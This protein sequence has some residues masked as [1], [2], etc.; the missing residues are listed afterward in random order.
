MDEGKPLRRGGE[1]TAGGDQQAGARRAA[2]AAGR[3]AAAAQAH[4]EGRGLH[5]FTFQLNVSAFCGK[6]GVYG[7]F[8]GYFWRGWR[9]CLEV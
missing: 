5:S 7:V 4:V 6:R 9:G 3:Q 2:A 8:R 1:E